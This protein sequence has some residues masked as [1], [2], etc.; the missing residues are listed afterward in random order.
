M[1]FSSILGLPVAVPDDNATS[2][3]LTSDNQSNQSES[4]PAKTPTPAPENET[5]VLPTDASDPKDEPE[6]RDLFDLLT[7]LLIGIAILAAAF[8][9]YSRITVKQK[10]QAEDGEGSSWVISSIRK[11]GSEYE[12]T[13]NKD[14]KKRTIKLNEKLYKKLI[15]NKKLTFGK[16]TISIQPKKRRQIDNT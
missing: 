6:G 12:I 1:A 5:G 14:G 13:V 4:L 15:K 3:N 9:L 16:H 2:E 10:G 11:A 7:Y 8:L